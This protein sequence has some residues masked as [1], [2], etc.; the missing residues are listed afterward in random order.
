[1]SLPFIGRHQELQALSKL[2]KKNAASLVVVQGRRRIGKSRLIEEFGKNYPFY[3]FSGLPPTAAASGQSER[4]EFARQ[5]SVQTGLPEVYG[6]D[7]S[8]LFLL[9]ADKIKEGRIVVLFDEISWM[10]SKD[11][12]FLGKL[13]NAWDLHFKKNP[14]LIF[15]L[16]GSASAWIEKNIL[17]N[18]GFM[19]RISYKLVLDELPLADCTQFWSSVGSFI[20]PYEKLKVL[21]VTGGVPRYLEELKPSLSAEENI[22]D[23]CFIK[24]GP[25]VDEFNVIFSDLFSTRSSTYKKI[26][27]TLAEGPKDIKAIC[28]L[29]DIGQTGFISECLEDLIKSGFVTRDYTWH[30]KSGDIARLSHFRL[31]DNYLRFYLKYIDKNKARIEN[32]E[33][34]F[35]SLASLPGWEAIMGLQF[36][37]LVLKNRKH[38]KDCLGIKPEEIISD[39][40]FFQRKTIRQQG[41]Q[42]DYL[43][44]TKFGGR[45]ACEIKFSKHPLQPSL[46]PEMKAK[47]ERLHYPKGFSCRPVLIHANGVHEDIN[48]C[49]YFAEII[50]FSTLLE[51]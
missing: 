3:H 9:L 43:I 33:F 5:L 18:T 12:D 16:C 50:D 41:C 44:Q 22:K 30:L 31:S 38:I 8:K 19:G 40:P 46:I 34:A 36:E 1:M 49:G 11:P 39:N 25:L 26:V 35:K 20:S 17:S 21:S 7:W 13:K 10:G 2:L 27:Q 24:G 4:N 42:I 28:T 23:L 47:L 51:S 29:L 32:D 14:Q 48:D 37:N 45:Y 15:I 6:D